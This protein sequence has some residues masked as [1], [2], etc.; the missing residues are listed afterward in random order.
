MEVSLKD[1]NRISN[2]VGNKININGKNYYIKRPL[3]K[4]YCAEIIAERLCNILGI[5][6]AHY[7]IVD[8]D[9]NRFYLSEV[10]GENGYFVT[11]S[12]LSTIAKPEDGNLSADSLY[13]IWEVLEAYFDKTGIPMLDIVKVYLFDIMFLNS[14]RNA[15]NWALVNDGEGPYVC[16]FDNESIFDAYGVVLSA[17]LTETDDLNN[18][19]GSNNYEFDFFDSYGAVVRSDYLEILHELEYFLSTSDNM[20]T[21]L[22]ESMLE[23]VTPEVLESVIDSTKTDKKTKDMCVQLYKKHYK[24]MKVLV[25][26]RG[27]NGKR[28]H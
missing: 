18:Y 15:P 3:G 26:A 19:S 21:E 9:G 23:K 13:Y 25:E 11:G 22:F 17:K 20:Y 1:K 12:E 2:N 5:K 8:I 14:D 7:E 28:I 6:T 24:N 27:K 10:L 16:I 4:I